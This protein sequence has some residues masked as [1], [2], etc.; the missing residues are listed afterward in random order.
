MKPFARELGRVTKCMIA[1]ALINQPISYS[2]LIETLMVVAMF[3]S[4]AAPLAYAI[5]IL[6]R[7]DAAAKE[8]KEAGRKPKSTFMLVDLLSLIF[9]VGIPFKILDSDFG[10]EISIFL[11]A[12]SII[13]ATAVW[14][15]TIDTI[16]IAGIKTFGWRA[17]VSMVLIPTMYFGCFY[18]AMGLFS[19]LWGNEPSV[20]ATTWLVFSFIGIV[21]SPWIVRGAL[22]SASSTVPAE[23][24]ARTVDPFA[25]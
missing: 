13:A 18:F 19:L 4:V 11:I 12:V 3:A 8:Q 15:T 6:K 20:E 23:T 14:F 10:I 25:D 5:W 22:R 1:E 2:S 9:L 17:L 21:A 7:L 16:S 24:E